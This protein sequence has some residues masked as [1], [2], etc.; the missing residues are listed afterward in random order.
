[1]ARRTAKR[2][3]RPATAPAPGTDRVPVVIRAGHTHRGV[4]YDAPTPYQATPAEAERLR[5]FGGLHEVA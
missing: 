4:T 2:A 5:A 1:M 3:T